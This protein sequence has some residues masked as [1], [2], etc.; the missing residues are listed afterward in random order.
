MVESYGGVA[1]V[2]FL[3]TVPSVHSGAFLPLALLPSLVS[4]R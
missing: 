3:P 2:S 4:F 1:V